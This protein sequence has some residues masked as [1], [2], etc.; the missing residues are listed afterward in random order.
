M[1]WNLWLWV[2]FS[3]LEPPCN[4]LRNHRFLSVHCRRTNQNKPDYRIILLP[5]SVNTDLHFKFF[6]LLRLSRA[7]SPPSK[8]SLTL[9]SILLKKA[10]KWFFREGGQG[11]KTSSPCKRG[12]WKSW[13]TT[14][15]AHRLRACHL[16]H[17]KDKQPWIDPNDT[18]PGCFKSLHALH[19]P[20][21]QL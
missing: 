19:K 21:Y 9:I 14:S 6:L 16:L 3:A 17:S 12:L 11:G 5:Y 20:G 7:T 4:G 2:P 13:L 1:G 10:M 15:R 8:L 18:I